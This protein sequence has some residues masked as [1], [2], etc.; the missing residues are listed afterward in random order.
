MPRSRCVWC[1]SSDGRILG[2]GSTE[3]S[4]SHSRGLA[5]VH[6]DLAQELGR[7]V[8]LDRVQGASVTAPVVDHDTAT[9]RAA[10]RSTPNSWPTWANASSAFCRW[11]RSWAAETCTRIRA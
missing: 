9:Y 1:F 10:P 6:L 2:P 5:S 11:W 4:F 3:H 8:G 7:I